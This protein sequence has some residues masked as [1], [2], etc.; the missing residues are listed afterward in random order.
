[1]IAEYQTPEKALAYLS[2]ADSIPN[3]THGDRM[4]LDLLP[5]Q[6]D[7][8]LDL[9][10]GDGRLMA[11]VLLAHPH[12]EG[13]AVD[14]SPTMIEKA[15]ERFGNAPHISVHHHDLEDPVVGFGSFDAVVSSFAIHHVEDPRKV[16]LYTEIFRVL[17]PGGVFI[18]LEHVSSPTEDLHDAF[19]RAC[20][21]TRETEDKSNRCIPVSTQLTW[22][23]QIGFTDV[24]CFWKWRE[25]AVL[26]GTKP[27]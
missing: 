24:D 26:A 11:L 6:V 2:M 22:L 21:S 1:M 18:N 10:T 14:F 25:L 3:R 13:V 16:D 27:N 4:V 9:G 8:V 23:E 20:G 12:A 19:L 5:A 7:R 15:T 17:R